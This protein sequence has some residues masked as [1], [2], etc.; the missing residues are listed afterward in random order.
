VKG[1]KVI[2]FFTKE[3]LRGYCLSEICKVDFDL[4]LEEDPEVARKREYY[5]NLYK[6]LKN[7]EKI[8]LSDNEYLPYNI[9]L[10]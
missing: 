3:K 7:S 4:L 9:E 5:S 6:I 2:N 10:N 1:I 8:M